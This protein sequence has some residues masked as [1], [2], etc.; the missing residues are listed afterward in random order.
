MSLR[1]RCQPPKGQEMV[2]ASPLSILIRKFSYYH[3]TPVGTQD[4]LITTAENSS[5]VTFSLKSQRL[6]V[7][8]KDI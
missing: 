8:G 3:H 2:K 6:N 5:L 7:P 1:N 4:V